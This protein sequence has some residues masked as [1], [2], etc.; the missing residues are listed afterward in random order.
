ME[1]LS[2]LEIAI[3]RVREAEQRV[4]E[5]RARV[6]RMKAAGRSTEFSEDLL[7]NLTISLDLMKRHLELV[8]DPRNSRSG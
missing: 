5:Q 6:E 8:T 4:A 2:D 3:L 1:P 7:R